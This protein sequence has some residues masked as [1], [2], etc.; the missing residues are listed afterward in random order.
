MKKDEIYKAAISLFNH[1]I[2]ATSMKK[3]PENCNP[4][5]LTE[6]YS[7]QSE[8]MKIYLNIKDNNIIGKKVGC[9]NKS[10]QKQINVNEPFYGN[11]FSKFSTSIPLI[12]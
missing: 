6:A 10:A 4:K 7:I 11:L 9:T 8:L 12:Y 1:R 3:L 2:N 5:N